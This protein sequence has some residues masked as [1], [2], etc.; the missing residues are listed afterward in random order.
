MTN[1]TTFRETA[2]RVGVLMSQEC[3]RMALA[4]LLRAG[5][6]RTYGPRAWVPDEYETLER[7]GLVHCEFGG[8]DF[9]ND[10]L[11]ERT[12]SLSTLGQEQAAKMA[13][14]RTPGYLLYSF[15][16]ALERI[17]SASVVPA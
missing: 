13:P 5:G 17:Q 11:R 2:H 6:K 8:F 3:Y 9:A 10:N 12:I 16:S 4:H 14:A 7:A 15:K 1:P